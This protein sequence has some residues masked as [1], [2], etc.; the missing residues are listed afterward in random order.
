[1]QRC[2][3]RWVEDWLRV[4]ETHISAYLKLTL[5]KYLMRFADERVVGAA[6][7][8]ESFEI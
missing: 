2:R 4:F 8:D 3:R 7:R 6:Y 5:R 1:L